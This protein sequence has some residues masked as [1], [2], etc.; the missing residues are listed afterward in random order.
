MNITEIIK[1]IQLLEGTHEETAQ[2]GQG[3][4]MNVIAYLNGEPQITDQSPCV[5][6]VVRPLAI[7]LN[8]FMRDDE[9]QQLIPY[10]HRAMGSKTDDKDE[11]SQ[12]AWLA[13]DFANEMKEIAANAAAPAD[14]A[15]AASAA[16]AR[17]TIIAEGLRFLDAALPAADVPTQC[18]IDRAQTLVD[19]FNMAHA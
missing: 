17:Q 6:E 2:T 7:W 10:I 11:L 14:A 15:Y 1:P 19:T 4:F 12:R 8:D 5:C 13:V 3:C 16:A 9:R 18:L